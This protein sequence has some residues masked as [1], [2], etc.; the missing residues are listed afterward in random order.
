MRVSDLRIRIH[1]AY[2]RFRILL[3]TLEDLRN[4]NDHRKFDRNNTVINI[5]QAQFTQ[6]DEK[7]KSFHDNQRTFDLAQFTD[8]MNTLSK[9][10]ETK[11]CNLREQI[12]EALTNNYSAELIKAHVS[13]DSSRIFTVFPERETK[14]DNQT[15]RII[16]FN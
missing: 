9:L 10:Q 6:L 7:I 5:I 16:Y 13:R 2:M 11:Y 8:A 1:S 4:R 14:V 15:F 3:L 12:L